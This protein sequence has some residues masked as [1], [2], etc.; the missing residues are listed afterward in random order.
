MPA[1]PYPLGLRRQGSTFLYSG[2]FRRA[3]GCGIKLIK[4]LFK[5]DKWEVEKEEIISFDDSCRFGDIYSAQISG[6]DD[7][8][9]AYQVVA[10]GKCFPD[11]SARRIYGL[12]KF[13]DFIP[14]SAIYSAIDDTASY[15]WKRD[16]RPQIPF[17]QSFFYLVHVRGYTMQDK[18]VE[19]AKRGTFKGLISKI[20]Y[21]KSLGVT[22]IELMPIAEQV[23]VLPK[24]FRRVGHAPGI[25]K[26]SVMFSDNGVLKAESASNSNKLNYWGFEKAY[27]Y[28]PRSCYACK[29]SDPI[30][31]FKEMVASFHKAGIEVI[32]QFFFTED[33]YLQEVIDILRFWRIEYHLDG[34]HLKGKN[35]NS[36]VIAQEPLLADVKILDYG[37]DYGR[38]YNG[39][40]I[41]PRK[42]NLCE[43]RDDFLYTARHF[44]KGDDHILS[45]FL[46]ISKEV[47][48]D[49]ANLHYISNYEGFCLADMVTYEHKHNE[50]NGEGNAD[51]P[52][53]NETWNCGVEGKS[54]KKSIV[55][56]RN[57]QIR[58]ALA[59][60]FLSQG[61][62][63]LYG[64]DEFGNS[65]DGNNNPYCQD[66]SI[67]WISWNQAAKNVDLTNYV[68]F[69]TEIRKKYSMIRS[70]TPFRQIDYKACGY[71]DFSYHGSEAWRPDL[72]SYS[73][74]IGM[75]Y[76]GNYV[77]NDMDSASIYVAYNMHWEKKLFALPVL[78]KGCNWKLLMDTA[79]ESFD[80]ICYEVPAELKSQQEY[81][82]QDRSICVFVSDGMPMP[83]RKGRHGTEKSFF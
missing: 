17:S 10:D 61:V 1:G 51:G 34:F 43:C 75:L 5:K 35:L 78:P 13:G 30:V 62:P 46:R 20:P 19:A 28:A 63:A 14:D 9:N 12:E 56:L 52:D 41:E 55:S 68:K 47:G 79:G 31:E 72:S 53:D 60:V 59:L 65:Q 32:A 16:E 66:N 3:T 4:L 73:H 22:T 39:C 67:G 33:M 26:S 57:K 40:Q 8:F 54:R 7:D 37:F 11:S 45:D 82:L 2:V 42:R 25:V 18:S 49:H 6:I 70:E 83:E 27:Y 29:D 58:N 44:L 23:S 69:L 24:R 74:T 64:G 50:A 80:K 21:L 15:D 76:C 36:T 71:P 48:Q 77:Q 38:I 81:L